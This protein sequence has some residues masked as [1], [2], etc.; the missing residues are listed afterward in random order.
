ML[1]QLSAA[2]LA[3]PRPPPPTHTGESNPAATSDL[4]AGHRSRASSSLSSRLALLPCAPTGLFTANL[5]QGAAR[6]QRVRGWGLKKG[7]EAHL[8]KHSDV[9]SS[10]IPSPPLSGTCRQVWAKIGDP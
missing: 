4:V 8:P 1:L 3:L 6:W 5:W 7:F 10:T 9:T 2:G